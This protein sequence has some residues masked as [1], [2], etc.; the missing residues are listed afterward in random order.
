MSS[1]HIA[2]ENGKATVIKSLL[3]HGANIYL[4][5]G[6]HAETPLHIA[7]RIDEAKCSKMLVRSGAEQNLAMYDGRSALHIGASCGNL[8]VLRSL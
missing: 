5:G 3:G 4:K 8:M 6:A 7:G 1:L 2:V